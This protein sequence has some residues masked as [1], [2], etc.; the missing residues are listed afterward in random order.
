M[1]YDDQDRQQASVLERVERAGAMA[2]ASLA[3]LVSV[4]M[5]MEH[6]QGG[7]HVHHGSKHG[8]ISDVLKRGETKGETARLPEEFDTGLQTPNIAG[9]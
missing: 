1:N 6:S 5:V 4:E 7:H 2:L 9:I 3:M 8:S